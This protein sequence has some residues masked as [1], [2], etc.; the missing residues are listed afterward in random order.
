MLSVL[1]IIGTLLATSAKKSLSFPR[2]VGTRTGRR[3]LGLHKC[4][5][6]IPKKKPPKPKPHIT[7]PE[8]APFLPGKWLIAAYSAVEYM[9]PFPMPNAIL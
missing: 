7:N 8:T 5:E 6:M 3:S 2:F 1:I 9:R 4:F